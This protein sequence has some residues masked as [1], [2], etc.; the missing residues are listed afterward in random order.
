MSGANAEAALRKLDDHSCIGKC[1]AAIHTGDNPFGEQV[2][3]PEI[4]QGL[5]DLDPGDEKYSQCVSLISS[6]LC[7]A[8]CLF[9]PSD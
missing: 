6:C 4:C 3:A 9:F 8:V 7:K 5:G 2:N 1:N